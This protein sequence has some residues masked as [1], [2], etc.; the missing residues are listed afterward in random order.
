MMHWAFDRIHKNGYAHVRLAAWCSSMSY[1]A[2]Y[3][4][5][6][7]SEAI[8]PEGPMADKRYVRMGKKL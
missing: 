5:R 8:I 7:T 4:F 6:Q 1:Y 2:R 3:G